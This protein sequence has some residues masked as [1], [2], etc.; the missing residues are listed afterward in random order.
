[1]TW[2]IFFGLTPNNTVALIAYTEMCAVELYEFE[3]T[4]GLALV[5]W[6]K[7]RQ[8]GLV[9]TWRCFVTCEQSEDKD[10]VWSEELKQLLWFGFLAAKLG[11]A[12]CQSCNICYIELG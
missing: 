7:H 12:M 10:L 11:R 9:V 4:A 6:M 3:T 5:N 8:A 1:M 2:G